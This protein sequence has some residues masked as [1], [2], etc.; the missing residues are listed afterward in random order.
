MIV[1]KNKE[2]GQIIILHDDAYNLSNE[3]I[4]PT[5]RCLK[6]FYDVLLDEENKR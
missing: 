2:T 4:E 5:R 3:F 1:L 6:K